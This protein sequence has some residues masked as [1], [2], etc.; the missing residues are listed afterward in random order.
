MSPKLPKQDSPS[1]Q[2]VPPVEYSDA[3]EKFQSLARALEKDVG[4]K[5]AGILINML[6]GQN[7]FNPNLLKKLPHEVWED[8]TGSYDGALYTCKGDM[9]GLLSAKVNFLMVLSW[10]RENGSDDP[11][12]TFLHDHGDRG[13]GPLSYTGR[14]VANLCR[15]VMGKRTEDTL[16]D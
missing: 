8:L 3:N 13:K 12:L 9:S 14:V 11:N 15:E 2:Q 10:G 5:K 16:H 7:P 4:V 1:L 6:L